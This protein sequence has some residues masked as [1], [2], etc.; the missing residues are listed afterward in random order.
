MPH[1]RRLSPTSRLLKDRPVPARPGHAVTSRDGG[2][3]GS[4][5]GSRDSSVG[6]E[7]AYPPP[8]FPP[9][10]AEARQAEGQGPPSAA[11]GAASRV[12]AVTPAMVWAAGRAPA[13]SRPPRSRQ[14]ARRLGRALREASAGARAQTVIASATPPG[15]LRMRHA[16][17][18]DAQRAARAISNA[19]PF[20]GVERRRAPAPPLAVGSR[21]R[22]VLVDERLHRAGSRLHRRSLARATAWTRPAARTATVTYG[23]DVRPVRSDP[24]AVPARVAEFTATDRY[25]GGPPR[26]P[27]APSTERSASPGRVPPA[28]WAIVSDGWYKGTQHADGQ[29]LVTRLAAS[30]CPVDLDRPRRHRR[31]PGDR[32][33]GGHP[34]RP[35]RDQRGGR[36]R[37]HCPAPAPPEP[38]APG[39]RPTVRP[40]AASTSPSANDR[41]EKA[42]PAPDHGNGINSSQVEK[43]RRRARKSRGTQVR[44]SECGPAAYR[45]T[46]CQVAGASRHAR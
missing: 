18:A 44:K 32:H 5:P 29:R 34:R 20:T 15:R 45:E 31:T 30:G 33:E 24:G 46:A 11:G 28:S 13:G 35:R 27:S 19:R 23:R 14:P 38:P 40:R 26:A 16:V 36:P 7:F 17:T 4:P 39:R 21:L 6:A 25:E 37:G 3:R 10:A 8:P 2:R 43:K 9:G 42:T 22:R 1:P 12:F 41:R